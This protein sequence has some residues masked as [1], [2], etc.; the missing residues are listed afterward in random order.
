VCGAVIGDGAAQ[1]I[2]TIATL[3]QQRPMAKEV[4]VGSIHRWRLRSELALNGNT[5]L[6]KA[7]LATEGED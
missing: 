7:L 3:I 4:S 2:R 1:A 6:T 5:H